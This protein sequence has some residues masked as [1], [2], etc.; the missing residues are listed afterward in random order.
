[1]QKHMPK[2]GVNNTRALLFA[3]MFI[4]ATVQPVLGLGIPLVLGLLEWGHRGGLKG[5]QR[6]KFGFLLAG[7]LCGMLLN[8]A[9]HTFATQPHLLAFLM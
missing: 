7:G 5:A 1:M 9:L 3:L 6:M 4:I 8:L 2:L